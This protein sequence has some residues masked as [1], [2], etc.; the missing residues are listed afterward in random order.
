MANT[1]YSYAWERGPSAGTQS[2]KMNL[3]KYS[4]TEQKYSTT[5]VHT[6]NPLQGKEF[7]TPYFL[8]QDQLKIAS[9]FSHFLR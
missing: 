4:Q 8:L 5:V 2:L 9:C 3:F 1:F 7:T 6:L